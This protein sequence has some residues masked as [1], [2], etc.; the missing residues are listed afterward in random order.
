[1]C[2]VQVL[3]DERPFYNFQIPHR[4]LV[5]QVTEKWQEIKVEATMTNPQSLYRLINL[6]WIDSSGR[7]ICD[8]IT[9]IFCSGFLLISKPKAAQYY[10]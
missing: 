3:C 1:M 5:Y 10:N 6:I 7:N 9:N 2:W 8:W 4:L